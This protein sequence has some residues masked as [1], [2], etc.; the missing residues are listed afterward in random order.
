MHSSPVSVEVEG[1][2]R[3]N[4]SGR[5]AHVV[6]FA[7][8]AQL[9]VLGAAVHQWIFVAEILVDMPTFN[10]DQLTAAKLP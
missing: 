1:G 9:P 8:G 2:G 7:A 5:R 3:R 6:L 10:A 4:H